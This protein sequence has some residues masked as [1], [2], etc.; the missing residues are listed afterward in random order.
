MIY[1][2]TDRVSFDNVSVWIEQLKS[3][4]ENAAMVLVGNKADC[5]EETT[6][7]EEEGRAMGKEFGVPFFP[8]SAKDGTNVEEIFAKLAEAALERVEK[9][10]IGSA[11]SGGGGVAVGS[12]PTA[13][14]RGCC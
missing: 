3:G 13:D 14:K 1:D 12:A 4:T 5:V 9:G 7:S 2:G 8:C 6:V 10:E 11:D